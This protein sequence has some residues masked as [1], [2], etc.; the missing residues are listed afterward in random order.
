MERLLIKNATVVTMDRTLGDI[1][2][3]DIFIVDG[4]TLDVA[5]GIHATEAEVVDATGMIVLP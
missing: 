1:T 5:S 3:G 2:G 4:R